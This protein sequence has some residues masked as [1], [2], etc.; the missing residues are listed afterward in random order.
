LGIAV[1]LYV[2]NSFG[3]FIRTIM[4][5]LDW[6]VTENMGIKGENMYD[7]SVE[8]WVGKLYR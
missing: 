8:N 2:L 6:F 7:R 1:G 3:D 4:F 5:K